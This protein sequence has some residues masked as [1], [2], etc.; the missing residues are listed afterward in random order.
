[1]W[2][3]LQSIF[4]AARDKTRYISILG[5]GCVETELGATQ[6]RR[7]TNPNWFNDRLLKGIG[8]RYIDSAQGPVIT[9]FAGRTSS[10]LD[11]ELPSGARNPL[12]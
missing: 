8:S 1:M 9:F 3:P 2:G 4:E 12:I 5:S 10:Q 7:E 11:S 6:V